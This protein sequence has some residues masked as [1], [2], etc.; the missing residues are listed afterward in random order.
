MPW[1][2]RGNAGTNPANDFLGTTDNQPLAIRT[3]S[4][5]R[6]RIT[7]DGNVGI[8]TVS[9]TTDVPNGRA[10]HVDNPNGASALRL[11]DGAVNG[12][13]WEWQSTVI[14]NVGA[15][16]LSKLTPPLANPLTVL[17]NGNVGIGT[18][19]PT[20]DVPNGRALHVDNPN[21]ASALRLG[22]GAAGGEQWEWQSTVIAGVGAMNL[23]KLSAPRANPL[24]VLANGNVG[25]GTVNPGTPL[26]VNGV[27][28][29]LSGGFRYPDGSVQTTATLRGPQGPAGLD[30]SEGPPGP[31]GPA[32]RTSAVCVT[33]ALSCSVVCSGRVVAEARA[34]CV[35]TSDTGTCQN[36]TVQGWCCVCAP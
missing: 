32:V 36:A 8:G 17:A 15:M 21:G 26:T 25:V 11:G 20:T 4:A 35:I 29:S 33:T 27:I 28:T 22:D 12:Q 31:P 30:G 34:G 13:Q 23:S 24:T 6:V 16:N 18:V 10:L 1:D 19:S 2:L 7:P 5:E 14:N 9:P 3:N